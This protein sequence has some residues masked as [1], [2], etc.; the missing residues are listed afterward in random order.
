MVVKWILNSIHSENGT[1]LVHC[2]QGVSRSASVVI[3]YLLAATHEFHSV[4][5]ALDFV[6]SKRGVIRPNAGF[7]RQL[8]HYLVSIGTRETEE[9]ALTRMWLKL[10]SVYVIYPSKQER[11]PHVSKYLVQFCDHFRL[12]VDQHGTSSSL[13]SLVRQRYTKRRCCQV[14]DEIEDPIRATLHRKSECRKTVRATIDW[15]ECRGIQFHRA[16]SLLADK[17]RKSRFADRHW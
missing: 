10:D 1:V 4:T 11:H 14:S 9:E 15:T 16:S 2:E 12:E 13:L 7:L 8:E 3:A 17:W 6:K 5:D